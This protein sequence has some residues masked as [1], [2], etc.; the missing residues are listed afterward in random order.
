MEF[1]NPLFFSTL[2]SHTNTYISKQTKIFSPSSHQVTPPPFP[3]H[4]HPTIP[5]VPFGICQPF[6]FLSTNTS[7]SHPP[8]P[9]RLAIPIPYYL[10]NYGINYIILKNVGIFNKMFSFVLQKLK[11]CERNFFLS[12]Q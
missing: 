8:T 1:V 2:P 10:G 5:Y 4:P 11:F 7:P 6:L 12:L 9:T 3:P